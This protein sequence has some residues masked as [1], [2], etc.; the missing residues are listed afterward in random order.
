MKQVINSIAFFICCF[1][2]FTNGQIAIPNNFK[3]SPKENNLAEIINTYRAE[4]NL[5]ELKISKN[6]CWVAWLH[7]QDLIRNHPDEDG[8]T[9]SSWSKQKLWTGGCINNTNNNIDISRNKPKELTSYP[10][11]GYE[12]TFW[13][14]RAPSID[15][16]V[17]VWMET[18]FSKDFIFNQGMWSAYKWKSIG[19]TVQDNYILVWFGQSEDPLSS[20]D[21][22][23]Q[24]ASNWFP[25][26]VKR[27]TTTQHNI[28]KINRNPSANFFLIYGSYKKLDDAKKAIAQYRRRDFPKAE[29]LNNKT[30]YRVSLMS[31]NSK[32]EARRAKRNLPRK[33]KD[34]WIYEKK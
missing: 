32:E 22:G 24:Y 10:S 23:D 27:Q 18:K 33:F 34:A 28:V 19:T 7:A 17:K 31:F 11:K 2:L 21:V 8:C 12:L 3:I 5:P 1:P 13:E 29:I 9:I 6:L 4:N 15:T 25:T 26:Q 20:P 14:N 30:F 16:A